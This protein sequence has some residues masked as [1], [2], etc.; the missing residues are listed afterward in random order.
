[1]PSVILSCIFLYTQ[2]PYNILYLAIAFRPKYGYSSS[3]REKRA[4]FCPLFCLAVTAK[5]PAGSACGKEQRQEDF[6]FHI[7]DID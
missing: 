1:M 4:V 6:Y 7:V 5:K 3:A 2:T